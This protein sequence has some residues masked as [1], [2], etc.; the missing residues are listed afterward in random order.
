MLDEEVK[1]LDS[2]PRSYNEDLAPIFFKK[3]SWG[4]FEIFNVWSNDVQSLFEYSLAA[5]L[6]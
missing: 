6:F 5:L 1:I 3:R 4:W 2:D